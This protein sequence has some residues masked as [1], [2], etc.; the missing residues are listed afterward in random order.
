MILMDWVTVTIERVPVTEQ[1]GRI[2]S[3][4]SSKLQLYR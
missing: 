1:S 3:I 4:Y 2:I